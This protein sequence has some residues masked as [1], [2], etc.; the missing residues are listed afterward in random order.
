MPTGPAGVYNVTRADYY[1][2][3][4]EA[5]CAYASVPFLTMELDG[6]YQVT[7]QVSSVP[8]YQVTPQV[9]SAHKRRRQRMRKKRKIGRRTR[10]RMRMREEW[11]EGGRKE[12]RPKEEG[13]EGEERG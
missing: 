1:R 10:M 9:S 4:D 2:E 8:S 12:G 7:P 11:Q 3:G 13:E 6:T 5:P